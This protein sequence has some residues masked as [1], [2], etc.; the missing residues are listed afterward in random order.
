MNYIVLDLELNQPFAFSPNDRVRVNPACPFEIIQIGAVKLN[1]GFEEV[2]RFDAYIKPK[3]Y[4]RIHPYVE[5]IT[6]IDRSRVKNGEPF[7]SAYEAF[8]QFAGAEEGAICTWGGDDVRAMIKNIQVH[9]LDPRRLPR[10]TLNVQVLATKYLHQ[11]PGQSIG[12]KKA[13]ELMGLPAEDAFHNALYDALYTARILQVLHQEDIP[14][15][16]S[17]VSELLAPRQK[18]VK[19]DQEALLN[20]FRTVYERSLSEEEAEMVRKAYQLGHDRAFDLAAVHRKKR[21]KKRS[22]AGKAEGPSPAETEQ[23]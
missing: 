2:G 22:Q 18:R 19:F 12:L 16:I 14:A 15:Y 21:R 10:H 7:P 17:P 9:Q 1:G 6:G 5:K 20:Y 8:L 11:T 13:V 3:L 4:P 23:D